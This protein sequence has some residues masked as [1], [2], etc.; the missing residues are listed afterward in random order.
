WF[1][2]QHGL[3]RRMDVPAD[4]V[5]TEEALREGDTG[6]LANGGTSYGAIFTGGGLA[7]ASLAAVGAGKPPRPRRPPLR[8]MVAPLVRTRVALRLPREVALGLLDFARLTT[9]HGT[10][11]Y[12]WNFLAM[13]CVLTVVEEMASIGAAFDV[14]GG[15]PV[16]YPTFVAYDEFAHRR[17]PLSNQA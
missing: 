8:V 13:R 15:A 1:D 10:T 3:R 9:S 7:W 4:V 6:L 2:R 5:F 14:L 11:R 17:G 12:E 16:I